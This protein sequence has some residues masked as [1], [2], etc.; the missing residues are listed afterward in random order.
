MLGRPAGLDVLGGR[1]H[2][3]QEPPKPG[4]A[5]ALCPPV[6]RGKAMHPDEQRQ[7]K[8]RK[9]AQQRTQDHVL[10][11]DGDEDADQQQG[12]ADQIEDKTGQES[13]QRVHVAVH[14][15]DQL[16]RR[17]RLVKA[18]VEPYQVCGQVDAQRV[19]RRPG[20]LLNPVAGQQVQRPVSQLDEE[21]AD[22]GPDQQRLACAGERGVDKGAHDLRGGKAQPGAGQEQQGHR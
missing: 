19:G 2:L 16:A 8:Q 6:R 11:P 3:A 4:G 15:F 13:G 17:M 22:R 20:H 7:G 9:Q 12:A 10:D 18:K 21:K 5:F 1:Q 14:P